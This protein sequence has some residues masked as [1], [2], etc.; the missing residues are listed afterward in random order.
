MV[1]AN[2]SVPVVEIEPV[3]TTLWCLWFGL[4]ALKK[5]FTTSGKFSEPVW[6]SGKALGW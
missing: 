4:L 2:P 5:T 1:K 3:L 6:P